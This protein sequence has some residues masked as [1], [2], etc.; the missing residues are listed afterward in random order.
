MDRILKNAMV[1]RPSGFKKADVLVLGGRIARI[2]PKLEAVEGAAECNLEGLHLFPG[3]IDVHVHLR[4]PGFSRKETIRTGSMAAAAG[5]YTTVC[6]MP[7][8]HPVPDTPA[9]LEE[10]LAI[11]RKC[12]VI[13]VVPYG[14]ITMEEKGRKLADM[15]GMAGRV[16]A[17]SDDGHGVQDEVMMRAAME[18][19]VRLQAIIAA[20]CEVNALLNKGYIHNGVYARAHGHRGICSE[21]EWRQIARDVELAHETGAKYH[22]CHI[23][24]KESVDIIRR[25]K[26]RGVDVTCETGP[27]YLVFCDED[28]QDDGRFKMNPPL[29]GREDRAALIEGILDGTIDMIATDHAPH[30]ADAKN[31]GLEGSAMGV[32]GLETALAVMYTRFVKTGLLSLEKLVELM[33]VNPAQRFGLPTGLEE[34]DPADIAVFDLSRE[35]VVQPEKFLSMGR[36]TPF[37]G[38]RLLGRCVLTLVGGK[39]AW[40]EQN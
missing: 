26:A 36:A 31:R 30:E 4:E 23:S 21:S 32:V 18:E 19:A 25:A 37:A 10:Q 14:A 2:A 29:R 20:H 33:A 13:R 24:A 15:A 40:T 7:N 5:G 39:C 27:H 35:W 17:F 1:Y 9:H 11:I 3:L 28:L 12:A 6:A 34:G 22:V 8:L 16:A 38:M